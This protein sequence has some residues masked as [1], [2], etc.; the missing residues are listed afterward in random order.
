MIDIA[1][2]AVVFI[3]F[4]GLVL[5]SLTGHP[6]AFI[7]MAMGTVLTYLTIGMS[8]TYLFIGRTFDQVTS[9]T[10]VA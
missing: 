8:G 3:M 7:M 2:V 5:M 9:G 6:I 10:L 1:P 4:G